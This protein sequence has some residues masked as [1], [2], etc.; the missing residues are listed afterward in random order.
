MH[1]QHHAR[2]RATGC[3]GPQHWLSRLSCMLILDTSRRPPELG[4]FLYKWS[5]ITP[6]AC[7]FRRPHDAA[8]TGHCSAALASHVATLLVCRACMFRKWVFG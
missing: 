8:H 4:V 1:V 2:E 7:G 3:C 6:A 5:G